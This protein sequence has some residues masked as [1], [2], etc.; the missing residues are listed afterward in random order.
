HDPPPQPWT[1]GHRVV[2]VR[3]IEH[4]LFDQVDDL[5]VERG[6][7]TV[8]DVPGNLFLQ[9]NRS[10]ADRC[11]ERHRVP[12]RLWGS[13]RSPD[14]LHQWNDVRRVEGMADDRALRMPALGL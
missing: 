7:D 3:D 13:L 4:S 6:L 12:D 8:G 11:V 5:A 2:G 10:L 9:M 14:D 1:P